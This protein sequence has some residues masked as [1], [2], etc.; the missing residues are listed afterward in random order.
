[1]SRKGC[2]PLHFVTHGERIAASLVMGWQKQV[3]NSVRMDASPA[4]DACPL[5]GEAVAKIPQMLLVGFVW[6]AL[7]QCL[8]KSPSAR[9]RNIRKNQKA[10]TFVGAFVDLN[11]N[12]ECYGQ[13]K[14]RR[15]SAIDAPS[16]HGFG[17][18]RHLRYQC[19]TISVSHSVVG[20]AS[21]GHQKT[22][23]LH[24]HIP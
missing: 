3:R 9:P 15:P 16:H 21:G 10:P 11:L 6:P 17:L 20:Y 23:N 2:A 7:P 12:L 8:R 18:Y 14:P 4:V 22:C 13:T 5:V 1:M 19:R 24:V